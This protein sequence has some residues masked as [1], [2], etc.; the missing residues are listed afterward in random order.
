MKKDF[1]LAF[2]SLFKK[3]RHNGIKIQSLAVGLAL[4][5]V[6]IAKVYF[7]QTYDNFYP[8]GDRVYM[9]QSN[10]NRE[11]DPP[12]EYGQ[13][14]GAIAPGMKT[15]IPEVEAATRFTTFVEEDA[16]FYTIDKKKYT[17]DFIMA[18]EH[19]FEV[20]P[21]PMQ[22]GN[23]GEVL[24][25][26]L[27]ALIS[28][29]IAQKMGGA[30]NI[31][32]QT[33]QL[34][35]YPGKV[36]TIGGVFEDVPENSHIHYDVVLSL[37]SIENFFWDGRD[38]WVGNDR[39]KGFVKLLPGVTPEKIAPAIRQMQERHQPMEEIKKAG[40]ELS[41]S[42][43][44]LEK[45]H[46]NDPGTKR[47][48]VLLSLLAFALL[49]TAVMNY[50]LVVI[51]TLVSRS[52][53]MAVYKCYG[54]S[55][56]EIRSLMLSETSV[57]LLLSLLA[58]GFLIFL[59]QSTIKKMVGASVT[60]LFTPDSAL[61]LAGICLLV[62]LVAGLVPAHLFSRIPV[63]AAF[64][65]L[66]ESRRNWKLGL[67]FIQFVATTF[68]VT[69]LVIIGRQYQMMIHDDP[70]YN[71]E[72]LLYC[73]LSG[74]KAEDRTRVM[75][76]LRRNPKVKAVA[77]CWELPFTHMSG[78][79][80]SVPG[81]D[82]ELFNYAD[83]YYADGDYLPLME[84]PIVEGNGFNNE[85]STEE[86]VLVS[87]AFAEKVC[88]LVNWKD[89]IVGKTIIMSEHGSMTVAGVYRDIQI[90]SL[91]DAD[92]RPT[93]LFFTK[94]PAFNILV[95][96]QEITPEL[97]REVTET[98]GKVLP[99]KDIVVTPYKTEMINLYEGA[100]KFQ[101]AV[102]IGGIATLIISL[103]GLIGYTNDEINRRRKEIAIRR[104]NGATIQKILRLFIIDIIRI[105]IPA[106]ILGG[107]GAYFTAVK[108]QEQFAEKSE[109]TPFLF[110]ACAVAVVAL[111]LSVVSLDCYR[112]ANQ[113][114]VESLKANE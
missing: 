110:I 22:I 75:E 37:A 48:S 49:F 114:P 42:L 14:S 109:L 46:S 81:N 96:L 9:I 29:S 73:D 69:L 1:I 38:N 44:P 2:R 90:S 41:Y 17:A 112:A 50:V 18:D 95:K 65:T 91:A 56:K 40:I 101:D 66:K 100:R 23:A 36:I 61:L 79:N 20:L 35:N 3:G 10:I 105:A 106:V 107:V 58:A 99:D 94:E 68:L 92:P 113:N 47:M 88:Q 26:P 6:L 5:L 53:E 39:Y 24:S 59:F 84:I 93:A 4:G 62:Y 45:L 12:K 25:R 51:S 97:I 80:V 33:I 21:R 27:Y 57:H 72:N 55:E 31:I 60:A 34:D 43:L 86:Q 64:R 19:F 85:T 30:A 71:Y 32:G 13:V 111:V 87:Q 74:T 15:D 104:V 98:F 76:E 77:S 63:A 11:N 89:G 83:M 70:G 67:L 78:N 102:M 28:T 16:V 82:R 52:K 54:A 108:W 103:I 8:D 7:E